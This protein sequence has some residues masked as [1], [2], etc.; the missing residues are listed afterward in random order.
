MDIYGLL[1][2]SK[3]FY[4]LLRGFMGFYGLL[5]ASRGFYGLLGILLSLLVFKSFSL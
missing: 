3:G 2:A 1:W 4:G 5:W